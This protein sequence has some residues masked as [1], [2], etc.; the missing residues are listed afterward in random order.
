M[1]WGVF[2]LVLYYSIKMKGVKGF[3]A[4]LTM[5]PFEAKS[6]FWKIVFMPANFVLEFV[7]LIAKPISHSLR[8]FGNMYAGE[9]IFYPNC[10]DVQR[11][12][13]RAVIGRW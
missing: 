13:V 7:S 6:T 12:F 11:R 4:E 3:A 1:A 9:M 8:L 2:G 10:F 5:Q